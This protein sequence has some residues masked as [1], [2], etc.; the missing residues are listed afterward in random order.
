MILETH[1]RNLKLKKKRSKKTPII[2]EFEPIPAVTVTVVGEC[3]VGKS[4]ILRRFRNA[5]FLEEYYCTHG[6][7]RSQALV[8]KPN[9]FHVSKKLVLQFLDTNDIFLDPSMCTTIQDHVDALHASFS[10]FVLVVYDVTDH[11]SFIEAKAWLKVVKSML[12]GA[13]TLI[14]VGNKSDDEKH[15]EVHRTAGEVLASLHGMKFVEVSA[16]DET[17]I[18]ALLQLLTH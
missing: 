5:S 16:K 2:E 7:E 9:S 12:V 6:V 15:R 3:G 14:L 10:N 17:N 13:A 8:D 11:S 18:S 1:T 4:S